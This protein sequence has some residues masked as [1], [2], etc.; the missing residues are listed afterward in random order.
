MLFLLVV[1]SITSFGYFSSSEAADG[2]NIPQPIWDTLQADQRAVLSDR[3]VVNVVAGN[4]YGTIIDAQSLNESNPGSNVGSQLGSR[5]ASAAYVDNAFSGSSRNW[6]YSATGHLTAQVAGALIGSLAD[7]PAEARFR[8]RYTIKTGSGGVEYLEEVRG[9]ALRHTVGICVALRPIRP[10]D[11]DTCNQ[12][13]E[14]FLAKYAFI[15]APTQNSGQAPQSSMP[16]K[17]SEPM[18]QAVT[19]PETPVKPQIGE[20]G[21]FIQCKIGLASP[22]RVTPTVCVSARGVIY[23]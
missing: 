5:Y 17:L 13:R 14:Q 16:T 10:V 15:L 12:T 7:R 9:D 18:S 2:L 23:Q 3:Y 4:S 1:I 19:L 6:N 22:I 20:P 21:E 8:T 11:F